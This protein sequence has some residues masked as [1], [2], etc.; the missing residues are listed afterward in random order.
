MHKLL[1]VTI[2]YAPL[3]IDSKSEK[4]LKNETPQSS[5]LG[6]RLVF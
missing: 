6:L 1:F 2:L 4:M 3:S 5:V